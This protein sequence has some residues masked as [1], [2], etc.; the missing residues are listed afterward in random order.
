MFEKRVLESIGLQVELPMILEVDNKGVFDLA[1]NWSVGG[2][3]RHTTSES[4]KTSLGQK[5][6][7]RILRIFFRFYEVSL[8]RKTVGGTTKRNH[9]LIWRRN[10]E[11][12][13][14]V[15]YLIFPY[16]FFMTWNDVS[17]LRSCMTSTTSYYLII[18]SSG[19]S[20]ICAHS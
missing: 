2:W 14:E 19:F 8:P 6:W 15:H 5:I 18:T 9:Y 13:Y 20:F 10:S 11:V 16:N 4:M 17:V 12:M 7:R 1:N 3:T